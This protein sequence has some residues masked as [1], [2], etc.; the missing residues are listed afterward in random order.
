MANIKTLDFLPAVFQTE[1]NRKFLNATLDQ[2]MS[3]PDLRRINAYVGR[4]FAPTFSNSDN[5]QPEPTRR[6]QNYQLEPTVLVQSN[7]DTVDFYSSYIDLLAQIEYYGGTTDDQSKLFAGESYSFNGLFDF[8]KFINFNQYYWLD[9]GPEPVNVFGGSVDLDRT[10]VVIRD[11]NS[12]SYFI[13]GFGSTSNPTM[14]LAYGGTYQFVVNQPGFPFWIQSQ[15]GVAGTQLNQPNITTRDVLGVENNGIDVGIVSFSVPLSSTQDYYVRMP[16]VASV[17]LST[18]L[19]YS[20]IQNQPL[21]KIIN[22]FNG[23]D[24]ITSVLQNKT[25]IFV[26]EDLDDSLW[27]AG[28]LQ[29]LYNVTDPLANNLS[30]TVSIAER[31]WTWRIRFV[32]VGT[33][34]P[35]VNLN[36]ETPV[37]KNQKVFVKSGAVRSQYSYYLDPDLFVYY[38]VPNLTAG[39]PQIYYQDS[40]ASTM[41]GSMDLLEVG[42][43]QIN[44]ETEI[45]NKPNY[46][47]PNGVT[48]TNGLQII[49]DSSVVPASYADKQYYVEG[50]GVA[51]T[52]NPVTN[53]VNPENYALADVP[54]YITINRASRDLN[55][56]SRSNRWFHVDVIR[57][58]AEYRGVL[59][60][61]DQNAR[62]N[63]PI[64]EFE[65]DLQLMDFGRQ[66]KSPI[67]I[68]DFSVT[69]AFEQ[70]QLQE[71]VV[72]DDVL[73]TDGMRVVFASDTDPTVRNNVYVVNIITGTSAL[74]GKIN[75][76]PAEDFETQAYENLIPLRGAIAGNE[77]YYDG[78]VWQLGQQKTQTNQ[79]PLFDAIDQNGVSLAEHN[80]YTATDF[81]G[82]HI[83]S[84]KPGTGVPDPVLNFALSYRNFNQIGDIQFINNF[85]TD[86][87]SYTQGNQSVTA[88]VNNGVLR[89]NT[90]LTDFNI[91]NI[92]TK[93]SESSKQYQIIS[94]IYDG[95]DRRVELDITENISV[96][97]PYF[98]VF[99]NAQ[100]MRSD[101]Y[102]V[103]QDGVRRFVEITDPALAKNDVIN[104]LMF[105]NQTSQLGYY[106]LPDNLEFNTENQVFDVLT[107]GQLRNHLTTMADNFSRVIGSVPGSSNIRD[108]NYKPQGGNIVQHA[109]PV[110]YS[111]LFLLD[112]D[113]NFIKAIDLAKYEYQ[114]IKNK[115][116]ELALQS[117]EVQIQDI[118]ALTDVILKRIN[119]VKTK[120]SPWYYSDMVP[121]GDIKNVI[122]YTVISAQIRGYE[123]SE[124]F[125]DTA[126]GNRAVLV[127]HNNVQLTKD[128]DFVFD[129]LRSGITISA[130]INLSADDI[131]R[132][133]E[134]TNTDGN[135]IPETPTKMGLYPKFTPAIFLDD[136]YQTPV[137]VVQGHDGSITPAFGDF[138]DQLLLEFERRIYNN[139]KINYNKNIFELYDFVPGK[140]RDTDYDSDTFNRLLTA[141]FLKWA[142]GNQVD[143]TNNIYFQASD[144]WTW[145]YRRFNDSLNG[146][147]LSGTWR[148]IYRYFYDTD[149]PH[150]HPWEMLGF[151]ERPDWWV[152]RYGPAPYTGGNLVLWNELSQGY[153][154]AGDR[155]GYDPR[156][157]R[158]SLLRIIPVD[159]RGFL[160][161]PESF[162]VSNYNS[163]DGNASYAVGDQGPVEAAW[164]RSSDYPYAIQRAIALSNPAFYFGTLMNTGRYYRN[165]GLDQYVFEDTLQR[166]TSTTMRV[167]GRTVA[168]E[169]ERTTGYI[170]WVADYL[171]NLGIDPAVRIT[172]YLENV[173]VQLSY[174]MAG[175]TDKSLIQVFAEQSSPSSTNLGVVVPPENYNLYMAK[176]APVTTIVYSAVIVEKTDNGYTVSGYNSDDP[177]FTI[178][179][180]L[181]N[182]NA[183][184][185]QVLSD[186]AV[187]YQDFQNVKTA[188]PYG[189]EFTTKQQVVDFLIGYERFLQAS[190]VVFDIFDETLEQQRDFKLSVREF[191]SWSQQGWQNG[192]VLVMSPLLNRLE[193]SLA[194]GVIDK[195]EN[196]VSA[197]RVLDTG[198]NFIKSNQFT[199]I[200]QE[201]NFA[202]NGNY[203]QTIGLAVLDVVEYEHALIFDNETVFNDIIYKPELGDRQ[204]RIKLVGN[205]TGSWTG[206][207]S[208]P[209]F[210]YNSPLVDLWRPNTDY[211]KG[212]LLSFKDLYYAALSDLDA[213]VEFNFNQWAPISKDQIKSG[214]LPNFSY[215]AQRFRNFYDL[216]NPEPT[217][218]FDDL[219]SASIGF[220]PRKYMSDFGIDTV[221]QAKF[222][223]GF[224]KEK[225]TL[226][227][228]TAFTAAGFN[229]V[230]SDIN[231]Y[232]EW[233]MR[234]GEYGALENNKFVEVQLDE[235][236]FTGDP[237]TFSL[238]SNGQPSS[239]RIVAVYPHDVYKTTDGYTPEIYRN[240]D[241]GSI[242]ENDLS[243]AG[244]VAMSEVDTT[245]FD[246]ANYGT[247]TNLIDQVGVGYKIWVAT[248][249]TGNWN[250]YRVTE[251]N[252]S[253]D[254]LSYSVDNLALVTTNRPHG[255]QYGDLVVV[256]AFSEL[257][258]GFY[259]VYNVESA[260]SFTVPMY[261]N[262]QDLQQTQAVT[263]HGTLLKLQSQRLRRAT[264]INNIQPL[265]TW[266]NGD[267][268]WVDD[269]GDDKWAVYEKT[270]PWTTNTASTSMTLAADTYVTESGFG[271]ALTV[272]YDGAFAAAGM[273]AV[274][275]GNVAVFVAN[276]TN[277]NVLTQVANIGTTDPV[278]RFG[279]SMDSTNHKLYV[280]APG[281]SSNFGKLYVYAYDGDTGFN[282]TQTLSNPV[283]I[284]GDRY[285]HSMSS[286]VDGTWLFV[287][288]P[289]VGNVYVYHANIAGQ[290]NLHDTIN[291]TDV[292]DSW[293]ANVNFG[294][295]VKTTSDASQTIVS[296]PYKTVNGVR[297]A[298]AVYV[299]DRSIESFIAQGQT[300][301]FT[302][303]TIDDT[304][305]IMINNQEVTSGFTANATAIEFDQA[306]V[307]GFQVDIETNHIQ[308]MEQLIAEN[309][310]SGAAFGQGAYISGNDSDI[311][312]GSPGYSEPGYLGGVVYR[313][314]NPGKRYGELET[315]VFDPVITAGDSIRINGQLVEF[316]T[317]N[318]I[319]AVDNINSARVPG[320]SAVATDYGVMQLS[321]NVVSAD[322][323]LSV[324]IG[325][326]ANVLANLGLSI[327]SNQQ[328]IRHLTS[329]N[330]EQF[331]GSIVS[332]QDGDVLVVGGSGGTTYNSVGFDNGITIFDDA[333]TTIMEIITGAGSVY[334]YGRVSSAL[335]GVTQDQ[336]V[337]VQR[338]ENL[339]VQ[340]GDRFGTALDIN[341]NQLLVGAPGD[342]TGVGVEAE[343][344]QLIELSNSG[345]IY[346]YHNTSGLVGWDAIRQQQPTVDIDSVARIF[347][348]DKGTN[349]IISN[350]DYIDP[351][352]GKILGAA[353]Q[354][355]DFITSYDPAIYNAVG[356][357]DSV[358]GDY[359]LNA[360]ARWG[361]AQ[362][363]MTWWDTSK[364]RYLDYEQGPLISRVNSWAQEFP[365]SE[366]QVCEWVVSDRTPDNYAGE[367]TP[368]YPD[369]SA[370]VVDTYVDPATKIV[371]TRYYFWVRGKTSLNTNQTSRMNSIVSLEQI[372]ANPQA[373]NIPYAAILRNDTISLY[374]VGTDVRG[375][376]AVVHLEY[377]TVRN[378]NII[379]SEFQLVQEGNSNRPVP[380]RIVQKILNSLSE[381]TATGL[382]LPDVSLLPQDQLGLER[383]KTVFSNVELA[384]ENW[385]RYLNKA[386]LLTPVTRDFIIDQLYDAEPL[387]GAENYDLVVASL[388]ELSYIRTT[389]AQGSSVL[390]ENYAVLVRVDASQQNLWAI[391]QFTGTEFQLATRSDG[392][393]FVQSY[394][395]PF[396]WDLIDWYDSSYD[397]TIKPNMVVGTMADVQTVGKLPSGQIIQILNN[398]RGQS[399][400]YRVTSN[401]RLELVGLQ[402][403]TIA[404][405]DRIFD[406]DAASKQAVRVI[407]NTVKDQIFTESLSDKFGEMIFFLINYILTEQK[408][409]DWV[410]KTSFVSV[411]HQLRKLEQFPNFIRDDQD[412]YEQYINEVKPYRTSL[413]EYLLDYQSTDVYEHDISDFDLPPRFDTI[414]NTF[415]GPDGTQLHDAALLAENDMYRNWNNHHTSSI[416]S[417]TVAHPGSGENIQLTTLNLYNNTSVTVFRGNTVTQTVNLLLHTDANLALSVGDVIAQPA[418]GASGLVF[419]DSTAN[420]VQ[421][422]NATGIFSNVGDTWLYLNAANTAVGVD[423]VTVLSAGA[424]ATVF[425]DSID[426]IIELVDV[427]GTF[428]NSNVGYLYIRDATGDI[429]SNLQANVTL[430]SSYI[431]QTGYFSDPVV[432]VVGGGGI[433]ANVIARRDPLTNS[434]VEFQVINPGAGYTSTP[435]LLISGPGQG[436]QAYANLV[437]QY[438]IDSVPVTELT[439][440]ANLAALPGALILQPNSVSRGTVYE[441]ST[442]NVV[443]L[444]N[445][446]G[447]FALNDYL[448]DAASNLSVAVTGISS[449]TRFVDSS[450]QKVRSMHTTM[451]FDR[452]GADVNTAVTL[453][454][455]SELSVQTGDRISQQTVFSSVHE[456]DRILETATAHLTTTPVSSD[457]LQL[458]NISGFFAAT[459]GNLYVNGVDSG[460]FLL[461]VTN[462]WPTGTDPRQSSYTS[463]ITS[464]IPGQ[465]VLQGNVVSYQGAAYQALEDVY[466][467][468]ILNLNGN[469]T[470]TIGDYL[471]QDS[472]GANAEVTVTTSAVNFITVSNITSGFEKRRGNLSLNTEPL[473]ADAA[474]T[475]V[476]AYPM[477]I[478][479]IFD[480]SKYELITADQFTNANDRIT[481]YYAPSIGMPE[482]SLRKLMDGMEYPGVN[483]ESVAFNAT[484]SVTN[485]ANVLAY[486]ST[487]STVLSA[488]A[489]IIDFTT[490][491]FTVGQPLR[492]RNYDY[493]IVNLSKPVTV[494]LTSDLQS[495]L[496]GVL[497]GVVSP[498]NSV[499]DG[500]R[501][502]VDAGHDLAQGGNLIVDGTDTGAVITFFNTPQTIS[503]ILEITPTVLT[504]VPFD[505]AC[506]NLVAC[507]FGSNVTLEYYDFTDPV[508]LDTIIQSAYTDTA[509]GNRPEDIDLD[510]GAYYDT[511]NSHA[512]QEMVPGIVFDN[513]NISVYTQLQNNTELVG[514]RIAHDMQS[515]AASTN[516]DMLPRYYRIDAAATTALTR[517]LRI[518]D[519]DIFVQDAGVFAE[520]DTL[521]LRP[522]VVYING[523]KIVFYERDIT[524]NRLGQ[525]RRGVDGTG[526]AELHTTGSELVDAS[527]QQLLPG[528]EPQAQSQAHYLSWL[529]RADS[530]NFN[531]VT[532][533]ILTNAGD[534]IIDDLGSDL[535]TTAV[536]GSPVLD[537]SGLEGSTTVQAMFIKGSDGVL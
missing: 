33:G 66:A 138:R 254:S 270:T 1:T 25:L 140:F 161:S 208:P 316:T 378:T 276:V 227:A 11:P 226:N 115:F 70:V 240:R 532:R 337:L 92:W 153:I 214:L 409:V 478:S 77:Y 257:Y 536:S 443:V 277:G 145:N 434:I 278:T 499:I 211:K 220:L 328:T 100:R 40:V 134:Y 5:Y 470:V 46:V 512:P 248:D 256:K 182:N 168:G 132:I 400:T 431:E 194:A 513:L 64:I 65:P 184:F 106:D 71:N 9:Q 404:I 336:Y 217:N 223:Q 74:V 444:T 26:N 180:S 38:A 421:V 534:Q 24:G 373:Q 426:S 231:L 489:R 68:L 474:G 333:S 490:L 329:E 527:Y 303:R 57:E 81:Q 85:D 524:T 521:F 463:S 258:D 251:T 393:A 331:G 430:V 515:N 526:A 505:Q 498:V 346:T 287:S 128:R 150:T 143:F 511:F 360:N 215:T 361:T 173:K 78:R 13:E 268:L 15:P 162:A 76:V 146:E 480:F 417:V 61:L 397:P 308:F 7:P 75:L 252:L 406:R 374:N 314:V 225:G 362:T 49:F 238:L 207:L 212:T 148:A 144:P 297:A 199:V 309:T 206:E 495:N 352:K 264:D 89:Q 201:N 189:F 518:T 317:G 332:S 32:D 112:T 477:T 123:I 319:T 356:S 298:G 126:L 160:R 163:I 114:K 330:V 62:A 420:V 507:P 193:I 273:P 423:S 461:S 213:T 170:N 12:G 503:N 399:V 466:S 135:F 472:T 265:K 300:A 275:N 31:R 302:Q 96:L 367:G 394:Y 387:P 448:Y 63:R 416:G 4:T 288:A 8:D 151:A 271:S 345:A 34:D 20:Q 52:L 279:S 141:P 522:G 222:Y 514:Y 3:T 200:R 413:R 437:G 368:L 87:F 41:V 510:G 381:T 311:Y 427:T 296:A 188:V 414:T 147:Q 69:D 228:I 432:T 388:D 224:V 21:S 37:D 485:G 14:K 229:G 250:V 457:S 17:D 2:L 465:T 243:T 323:K 152:S 369:G 500:Q 191:L 365:G 343:S 395:I 506:I 355:L 158:P 269:N 109:S 272:S 204:F 353:E 439:L 341:Q 51:I 233:G 451:K 97:T 263:G 259:Q 458:F 380:D 405:N 370:Y 53:F 376:T 320:V 10:F 481:A 372:I 262:L 392:T 452:T 429:T 533:N 440:S 95:L 139:I 371:R 131:I 174:K 358:V 255:L 363:G 121:Y 508:N 179:P 236:Q 447:A 183:Y 124:I 35:V 531:A 261:Q 436:A 284:Q 102:T 327:Y 91:R 239:D 383:G 136:T 389:D 454:L 19:S 318:I 342:D 205:K 118:P 519:S 476:N 537:G 305:R 528:Q 266:T 473:T 23:V 529:N 340:P 190:G 293:S 73:L 351:A 280:G 523:E 137:T 209:G 324:T 301:F 82:T 108:L 304:V 290:Y 530:E 357:V 247:L 502:P 496:A 166:V 464:W 274:M 48:L 90:S 335:S 111:Q 107:L 379:H 246:I 484:T 493:D 110:M 339:N 253:V 28:S 338:L 377:D 334:V 412:Y 56:W 164:R 154:H 242:Y 219:S 177:Y 295:V 105:S 482:K 149:R 125:N 467:S 237:L 286:S 401:G 307:L 350:L 98:R 232:E 244:Y 185:I 45:L 469:A 54:D 449:V 282:L 441:S 306:P 99:K 479:N 375:N 281:D 497:S 197:S 347:L 221:T 245:L 72:L 84:Y 249:F 438:Q 101:L 113:V 50:V 312:I 326:N 403:G 127:Y 516:H 178:V 520:P 187:I 504:I 59:F 165:N 155:A 433:G 216:D 130:E 157:A 494:L 294:T 30:G 486:V 445:V 156:F 509:L 94:A 407:F 315:T 462:S 192:N 202:L 408:H 172:S 344:E 359:R 442:G 122:E 390:P 435:T 88:K 384:L 42:N 210:V 167:N 27:T 349:N 428:T 116:L 460:V 176:S 501:V 117:T 325:S 181:A 129:T 385:V 36:L 382:P 291:A 396:Y 104:V 39:L 18:N 133:V 471:T 83:F 283:P 58:S 267:R 468:A 159:D 299:F 186:T 196:T 218:S 195:I 285:A 171:R 517:D 475:V 93:N 230:T 450:Y 402:R 22:E 321:S 456:S 419:A 103:V 289:T 29:E 198:F 535:V 55:P 366:I 16:L 119:A 310:K 398:G 446:Q 348:Y 386:F 487:D 483:L 418:T 410:F 354:D 425:V 459:A 260:K 43:N 44:V 60:V 391:Y 292:M 80:V 313:F 488:N 453:V 424:N 234:V 455:S 142:G 322:N 364:V 169:I 235:T 175:F 491:G 203:G 492:V 6:R 422:Y 120:A 67:D 525:L 411:I 47:S 86:T 79:L 415:R 241:R